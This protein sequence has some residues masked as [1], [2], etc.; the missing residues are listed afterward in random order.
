MFEYNQITIQQIKEHIYYLIKKQ[1]DVI[2]D[3]ERYSKR[4]DIDK[5]DRE[6]AVEELRKEKVRKSA[7]KDILIYIVENS[8]N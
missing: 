6:M 1:D 4:Q 7:Y 3:K 2:E 5:Y 8:Y